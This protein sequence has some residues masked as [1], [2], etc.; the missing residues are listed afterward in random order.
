MLGNIISQK[1]K[2]CL[3]IHFHYTVLD[4]TSNAGNGKINILIYEYKIARKQIH[5][6]YSAIISSLPVGHQIEF[7]NFLNNRV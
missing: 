5:K 3:P 1:T 2:I 7:C 4:F 6:F